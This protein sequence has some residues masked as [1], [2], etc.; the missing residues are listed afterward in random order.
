M[1]NAEKVKKL[2][3]KRNLTQEEFAEI[4]GASKAMVAHVERGIRQPSV[5]LLKRIADYFACTVD[6]L[7]TA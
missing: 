1:V 6:S 4:I 2:R 3:E 7:L 5:E